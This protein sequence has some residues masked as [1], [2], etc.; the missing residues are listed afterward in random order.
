MKRIRVCI[1]VW[2][3]TVGAIFF[4]LVL[5][6]G[7]L[8]AAVGAQERGP[9]SEFTDG[10]TIPPPVRDERP[11][12]VKLGIYLIQISN[13]DE[14]QQTFDIEGYL[15]AEWQDPRLAFDSAEFGARK[16]VYQ[17]ARARAQLETEI[18]WPGVEFVN[19]AAGGKLERHWLEIDESGAVALTARFHARV[20]SSMDLR[21]FPYDTQTL[22]IPLESYFHTT[23]EVVF[24][25]DEE[26]TGYDE[27]RTLPEWGFAG[28]STT[29]SPHDYQRP[30]EFFGTYSRFDFQLN[31]I[32]ESGFYHWKIFLPLALIL[33]SSWAVF[34][35]RE[36]A[37]NVAI[38]FTV[39]LTVVAFNFSIA[40]AL[41][42]VPYL[43]F[44]NAVLAVSYVSVFLSLILVMYSHRLRCAE[45][46]GQEQEVQRICRWAFPAGLV[47]VI[48][49]ISSWFLI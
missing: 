5:G 38:T 10:K 11:V 28:W 35:V 37:V 33:I 12:K 1:A 13:L 17:D 21:R 3:A 26:F 34:W 49:W 30:H 47:A 6:V 2:K 41:P 8:S 45:K 15:L 36:L 43:T 18:W 39:M 9:A 7:P 32:R 27:E 19:A 24:A 29:V 46:D 42:K 14:L 4:L 16:K 22:H 44:L 31:L 23:D 25:V 20:T 40:D 48:A